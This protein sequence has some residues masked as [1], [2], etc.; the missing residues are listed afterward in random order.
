MLNAK[1][2]A[3]FGKKRN[4]ASLLFAIGGLAFL[5]G[6]Q[7][8]TN[9]YKVATS[10]ATIANTPVPAPA[11][12]PNSNP[13]P[14][15]PP[16]PS[17][18]FNMNTQPLNQTRAQS[19]YNWQSKMPGKQWTNVA[20]S[21]DLSHI[22]ATVSSQLYVSVD[23]GQS[24]AQRTP[25]GSQDF[26]AIETSSDGQTVMAAQG[27]KVFLSTDSGSTWKE[28]TALG[29]DDF[30]NL[31][32]SSDGKVILAATYWTGMFWSSVD[33]GNT[34]K[35][36]KIPFTQA[37]NTI[38]ESLSGI[39][40]TQGCST[41]YVSR[42]AAYQLAISHDFGQTWTFSALP[43][44]VTQEG[45]FGHRVSASDNGN[46]IAVAIS[47]SA[48]AG[49]YTST[50][51][52]LHWARRNQPIPLF[53][54]PTLN[55]DGI[56]DGV[57]VSA[58][59]QKILAHYKVA[60]APLIISLDQGAT[61][62]E[63]RSV[64]ESLFSAIAAS[65][66]LDKIVLADFSRQ[67]LLVGAVGTYS[68]GN[69]GRLTWKRPWPASDIGHGRSVA[70]SND[71]SLIFAARDNQLSYS[72]DGGINWAIANVSGHPYVSYSDQTNTALVSASGGFY[73]SKN[74]GTSWDKIYSS[75]NI[76][77]IF[78]S[79]NGQ[80]IVGFD[81]NKATLISTDGGQNWKNSSAPFQIMLNSEGS[82]AAGSF[83]GSTIYAVDGQQNIFV[84]HDTATTWTKIA[85]STASMNVA[86]SR[87]CETVV[88]AGA[89]GVMISTN[90]GQS[91]SNH[92]GM[93]ANGL[94]SI[95][96][97]VSADGSSIAIG[98]LGGGGSYISLS[99]DGGQSWV[100]EIEPG[101]QEWTALRLSGDGK[102]LVGSALYGGA[103]FIGKR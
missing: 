19:L 28:Q 77:P 99:I 30:Y 73:V 64:E 86:C 65:G 52:G 35:H 48:K 21:R 34:W 53:S 103:L 36:Q 60:P 61:W 100:E 81:A 54:S 95:I 5:V 25:G 98:R 85:N 29:S 11:P 55:Y 3:F 43:E 72:T 31:K 9:N 74:S 10:Q 67:Q 46:L 71:G 78:Y 49:I 33:S 96:V 89:N 14:S 6:F 38:G 87:N 88:Y 47:S 94:Y 27:K 68:A 1:V 37:P 102:T 51:S 70:V 44:A 79:G 4:Q 45:V 39:A 41:I 97:T 66:S 50:D 23:G 56:V 22:Y 101:A 7:N 40:C 17:S 18:L 2:R 90:S 84:S 62:R 13:S 92:S 83:D 20:A 76:M 63:E 91:F 59:G 42:Q 8:C 80:V 58:D 12:S 75:S 15:L 57:Q 82:V 93:M 26:V 24:F 69:A 16:T 32:V